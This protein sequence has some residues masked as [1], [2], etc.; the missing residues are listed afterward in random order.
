MIPKNGRFPA[1]TGRLEY[2]SRSGKWSS[3]LSPGFFDCLS[4]FTDN[5]Q[6]MKQLASSCGSSTLS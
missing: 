6:A 1:K 3:W 5:N 4:I 2:L